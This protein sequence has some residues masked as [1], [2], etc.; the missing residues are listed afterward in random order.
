MRTTG[1]SRGEENKLGSD[2]I[3]GRRGRFVAELIGIEDEK[4]RIW[5]PLIDETAGSN[6]PVIRAIKEEKRREGISLLGAQ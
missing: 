2:C 6:G 5:T 4:R 3:C 1:A